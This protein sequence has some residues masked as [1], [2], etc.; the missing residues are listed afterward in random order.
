MKHSEDNKRIAKNTIYLYLRSLFTMIVSLYTSRLVLQVLGFVDHGI[1][2][3]IGSVVVMFNMFSATFVA[4]TQ[5]FLNFAIG[6]HDTEKVSQV[7]SASINIHA[8][9]ACVIFILLE[10]VGLWFMNYKLNIPPERLYAANVVYQCSVITFITNLF[11]IPFNA[12]IIANENMKIFALVSVYE[13][14]AKLLSVIFISVITFD[15]L[16]VYGLFMTLI[17]ISILLF[18]IIHCRNNYKECYYSKIRDFVL[19][20]DMLGLSAWNFLGSGATIITVSGMGII[21]NIFTDVVVN[22]AKGIASQVENMVKQL[23]DNFMTSIRPQITKSFAAGDMNYLQSLISSGSRFSL[24]MMTALCFPIILN[25]DY[26][27][28]LWLVEVPENTAEFVIATLIYILIVP[29]SNI[30]DNVLMATGKIK[31][32]QIILSLLQLINIPL[33]CLILYM[34]YPPYYIYI[35]YILISYISLVVRIYFAFKYTN[36]SLKKYIVQTLSRSVLIV[37]SSFLISSLITSSLRL[38]D[39]FMR[40]VLNCLLVETVIIVFS[41]TIGTDAK[42]RNIIYN[43]VKSKILK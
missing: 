8:I 2:N 16:V 43:F 41:M 39:D 9:L 13:S 29:F 27:L 38:E 20:K 33:A 25:V 30:L 4:S 34:R 23:V 21:I 31:K 32:S 37:I 28:K 14:V 19:Y 36:I 6:K 11:C 3:L 35:S 1:Y 10:T 7:Y 26:I 18:Y 24:Y 40:F 17:P 42:E 5:R 12:V 15:R 22:S